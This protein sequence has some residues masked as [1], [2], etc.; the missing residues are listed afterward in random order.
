MSKV[1]SKYQLTVPKAIAERYRIRPGDDLDWRP[2]GDVIHLLPS[3]REAEPDDRESRLRIFDQATERIRRRRSTRK[4]KPVQQRG[5][6][7]EDLYKRGR[8]H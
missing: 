8:A 5:W 3:S 4:L 1:T 6:T 7:R 2:A